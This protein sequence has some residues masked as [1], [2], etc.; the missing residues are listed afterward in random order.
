MNPRAVRG[1]PPPLL[2]SLTLATVGLTIAATTLSPLL[3]RALAP[4]SNTDWNQLSNI[5][6]TYGAASAVLSALALIAIGASLV[7]QAR[8]MRYSRE[9][10]ERA[11]HLNLMKLHFE[12]PH[13]RTAHWSPSDG[14][15][16]LNLYF[17]LLLSYWETLYEVGRL[18]DAD[19]A[20]YASHDLF[21]REPGRHFW[22]QTRDHRLEMA[23][24]RRRVRLVTTIDAVWQRVTADERASH[25]T[26]TP[27]SRRAH[28]AVLGAV[29]AV[30]GG[31]IWWSL[32]K[33][34]AKPST[35]RP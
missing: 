2:F 16:Q 19:L 7:L 14:D 15:A 4:D 11:H 6:Q 34:C 18:S 32:S 23:N 13:L 10:S 20:G 17:N 24:T 5:G 25:D 9:L 22:G 27:A 30:A 29:A 21:H 31:W 26:S 1:T 28:P 3:L 33:R 35:E 12:H 8:E